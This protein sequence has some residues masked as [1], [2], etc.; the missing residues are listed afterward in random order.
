[1]PLTIKSNWGLNLLGQ[2]ESINNDADS[3]CSGRS[4]LQPAIDVLL[5][6]R[7]ETE[8][9]DDDDIE[10]TD[11]CIENTCPHKVLHEIVVKVN[12]KEILREMADM[13]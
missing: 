6:Y 8:Y 13:I 10:I 11:T 1:M 2:I 12:G 7:A 3:K 9:Y 4:S 5:G